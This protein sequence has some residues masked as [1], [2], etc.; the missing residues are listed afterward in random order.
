MPVTNVF[1]TYSKLL[2]NLLR[3]YYPLSMTL[4]C[5]IPKRVNLLLPKRI[6][7]PTGIKIVINNPAT[8]RANIRDAYEIQEYQRC[9][10]FIPSHGDVV[11]DI[12]SYVGLFTLRSAKKVGDAGR[13]YAFEP[14]PLAFPYLANNIEINHF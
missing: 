9:K 4:A 7:L 3:G 2:L 10:D 5:A 11:F 12:G 6:T 14:N 1:Q 13:V 8:L